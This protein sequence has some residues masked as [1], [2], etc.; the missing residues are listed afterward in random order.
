M[1]SSGVAYGG[2]A[3][4]R[5]PHLLRSC[6]AACWR[7]RSESRLRH[8][9][10]RHRVRRR[11]C[12]GFNGSGHPTILRA[13][14]LW[15]RDPIDHSHGGSER[16]RSPR[17][18]L[19][20]ASICGAPRSAHSH[21]ICM[22]LPEGWAR[23]G[24]CVPATTPRAPASRFAKAGVK[25]Y[26]RS[27]AETPR[28]ARAGRRGRR[29]VSPRGAFGH[30]HPERTLGEQRRRRGVQN[31]RPRPGCMQSGKHRLWGDRIRRRRGQW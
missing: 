31:G 4:A 21:C 1:V 22:C 18:R 15:V 7:V 19:R 20:A 14:A 10:K 13:R 12:R 24:M 25:G 26:C 11:A 3:D 16:C 6:R 2:E 23:T 30:S 29:S 28:P 5:L 27:G 17:L 8:V 9:W